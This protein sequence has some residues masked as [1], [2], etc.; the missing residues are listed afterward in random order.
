MTNRNGFRAKQI[1]HYRTFIWVGVGIL[2]AYAAYHALVARDY[3]EAIL[4]V[5]LGSVLI[6]LVTRLNR[7]GHLKAI[8]RICT[9]MAMGFLLHLAVDGGEAGQRILWSYLVPLIA[10]FLLGKKEGLLWSA[11][12]LALTFISLTEW[13]PL[14]HSYPYVPA[15]KLRFI[16]SYGIMVV[17]LTYFENLRDLSDRELNRY[18]DEIEATQRSLKESEEKF[19][20][21]FENS[22]DSMVIVEMDTGR[23]LEVNE[24][25]TRIF[26]YEREEALGR[27][28]SDLRLWARPEERQVWLDR[29]RREGSDS[30]LETRFRHKSGRLKDVILSSNLVSHQAKDYLI[31][32]A[33]DVTEM[34]QAQ[35]TIKKRMEELGTLNRISG[36]INATLSLEEVMEAALQEVGVV[37]KPDA[38]ML[39]LREGDSLVM[40]KQYPRDSH[41]LPHIAHLHKV[42]ECLCGQAVS[43]NESLYSPDIHADPRCTLTECKEI[44]LRAAF[45]APLKAGSENLG[46]F[47]LGFIEERRLEDQTDFLQAMANEIASAV[48][49]AILYEQIQSHS[50]ELET[51]L[52]QIKQAEATLADSMELFRN[53]FDL[54]PYP[55]DISRL[56]DGKYINVNKAFEEKSGH[57][58]E[59]VIGRTSVELGIVPRAQYAR[60]HEVLMRDKRVSNLELNLKDREGRTLNLL[61]SSVTLELSG[62]LCAISSTVDVTQIKALEKQLVQS[63][64]M[65][66]I[67]TLAGGIAHDFNNILAIIHGYTELAFGQAPQDSPV[68]SQL[69]SVL[70]ASDRAT[71]LVRHILAFSRQTER[72]RK[73][74]EIGPV[75]GESLKLL[76]ASIPKSIEMRQEIRAANVTLKADPTEIHQIV[77]N[78]CT[79]A[80]QAI[81]EDGGVISVELNQ[82]EIGAGN[83]VAALDLAPGPYLVL[84]V[85]D[86]GGGIDQRIV[87]RIFDPYFTTK[88]V[89]QGTGFG[90]SL[91]HRIVDSYQGRIH[92]YSEPGQGAT[93]TVYFPVD[94]AVKE[95]TEK[96]VRLPVGGSESI[97]LVDDE[98][99]IVTMTTEFLE[100]LGYQVDG[101]T[102][103]PAA[104]ESFRAH[105]EKYQIVITDQT[106]PGL[107]GLKLSGEIRK[108]R[109]DL[110]IILCTGFS[111]VITPG[112]AKEAGL[113]EI[114]MKPLLLG[115]LAA[116]VRRALDGPK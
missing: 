19:R 71:D 96:M 107:T 15:F 7:T 33:R 45:V 18:I 44:G 89:G 3:P 41:H 29:L 27:T 55:I 109:P 94:G 14:F 73:P 114:L 77:M 8:L 110:P 80:Y 6:F 82:V 26:G 111:A 5:V 31:S 97:L 76:R 113:F 102:R 101:H 103:S 39:F 61:F 36:I 90:L 56:S 54:S 105:P 4:H 85:S 57:S 11:I 98:E 35:E 63:Q 93:F 23:L 51:R 104:L 22:P 13:N 59:S 116:S 16:T 72:E 42:G 17:M 112:S 92:V 74:V 67:G 106:M 66:A 48:N 53:V 108:V 12:Y 46:V 37:L 95:K 88:A 64:K 86:T 99:A 58:R 28:T 52:I 21:V 9:I 40:K 70:K 115:D 2:L 62:E 50:A 24:A 43:R 30:K 68:K 87:G 49:N 65:E 75:V 60:L 100:Q 83:G 91:V 20:K 81:G 79:N 25:F 47:F 84:R 38:S 69:E 10:M 78:L 32:S 34:A 1:K